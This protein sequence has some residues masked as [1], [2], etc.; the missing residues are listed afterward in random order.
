MRTPRQ[1]DTQNENWMETQT[2]T[3]ILKSR[4]KMKMK[5]KE[6]MA[7]MRLKPVFLDAGFVVMQFT[8]EIASAQTVQ[9][10]GIQINCRI[11][12]HNDL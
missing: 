7:Q 4:E 3:L 8:L 2:T 11:L 5:E 1:T 12:I 6:K 10:D 9:N